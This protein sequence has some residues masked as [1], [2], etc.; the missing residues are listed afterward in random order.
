MAGARDREFGQEAPRSGLERS[1]I[2]SV[3][4]M[5]STG[6]RRKVCS[7]V[8]CAQGHPV[9]GSCERLDPILRTHAEDL[10][11]SIGIHAMEKHDSRKFIPFP[12]NAVAFVDPGELSSREELETESKM[13][14]SSVQNRF[15]RPCFGHVHEKP[16]RTV[17]KSLSTL[18]SGC[19]T[20]RHS[21]FELGKY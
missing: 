10:K 7:A 8:W 5:K 9:E 16:A 4:Q 3:S 21:N 11:F 19:G 13:K 14:S 12:L 1:V 20:V 18:L 2:E 17:V 6:T 15:C